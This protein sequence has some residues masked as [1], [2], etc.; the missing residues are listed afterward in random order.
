M[1]EVKFW[2]LT[3][4]GKI[5]K[6]VGCIEFFEDGTIIVNEEIPVKKLIQKKKFK[7]IKMSNLDY[8]ISVLTAER[9]NIHGLPKNRADKLQ[10]AI[11][12]LNYQ[13]KIDKKVQR[14]FR[15]KK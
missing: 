3:W 13:K 11:D 4:E 1:G 15:Q 10:R 12:I 6:N 2:A 8:P 14:Y 7:E 9:D 5:I